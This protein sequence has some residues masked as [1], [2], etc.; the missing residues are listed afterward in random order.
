MIGLVAFV[1]CFLAYANGAN[2]NFKGVASLYG[3]GVL[4]YWRALGWATLATAAGSVSAL[5]FGQALLARF[6]GRGLVTDALAA[7]PE[8]AAAVAAGAGITVIL[9]A[10]A[11]FP[12]STTHG[13][14]GAITGAGLTALGTGVNFGALGSNFLLPLLLSPV[15]AVALAFLLERISGQPGGTKGSAVDAAHVISAGVVS[16]ARGLNDAPKIAAMLWAAKALPGA[17]GFLLVAVAMAAGGLA[18]SHR[19]ADTMSLRLTKLDHRRGLA[20]NLS[21]SVLVLTA[22]WFGLPVSTTHVSVGSLFGTG[23]A[24]R[25]SNLRVAAGIVLS[26]VLTLPCAA[27]A[28]AAVYGILGK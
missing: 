25:Q 9:A 17:P 12:I 16:F 18:H 23:I 19:I 28:A 4:S 20:A 27:L 15:I 22:T 5:F 3:G 8:F 6:T 26:W 13:L 14:T 1:V 11:G 7:S 24:A 2:D 21:T 10:L